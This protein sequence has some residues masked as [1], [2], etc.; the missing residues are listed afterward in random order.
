MSIALSIVVNPSPWLRRWL[1]LFALLHL[2]AALA[3]AWQ[4]CS[5]QAARPGPRVAGGAF[6]AL[7]C[8]AVAVGAGWRAR[9]AEMRRRIDISGL[10]EIRLTVQHGVGGT[11]EQ[12]CEVILLPG[13][14]V[15]PQCQFLLFRPVSGGRPLVLAVLPDSVAEAHYRAL[16]VALRSIAGRDN[17]FYEINKIL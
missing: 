11:A 14:T 3:L 6:I 2:A 9:R 15:W 17:K 4:T 1:R 10:G 16:A 7:A 12:P 8:A 13:S 5:G